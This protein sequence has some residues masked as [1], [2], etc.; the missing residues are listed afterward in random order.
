ML[1]LAGRLPAAF[2]PV[3]ALA[4]REEVSDLPDDPRAIERTV[5]SGGVDEGALSRLQDRLDVV[6]GEDIFLNQNVERRHC[7]GS[8]DHGCPEWAAGEGRVRHA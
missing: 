8:A 3:A 1:L 6:D 2:A 4:L 5:D 7:N